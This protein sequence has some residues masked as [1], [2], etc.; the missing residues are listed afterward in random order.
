M[1]LS[2]D[3]TASH[4][5]MACSCLL[6]GASITINGS[7]INKINSSNTCTVRTSAEI[8]QDIHAETYWCQMHR[9]H[10]VDM[11]LVE[12]SEGPVIRITNKNYDA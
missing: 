9:F 4:T 6:I 7:T 1:R 3:H 5:L 11:A 2:T 12:T 10:G 8:D